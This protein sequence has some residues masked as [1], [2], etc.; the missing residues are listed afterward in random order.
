V[1]VEER[2]ASNF[3]KECRRTLTALAQSELAS[4]ASYLCGERLGER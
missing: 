1:V 4:L 3:E 2:E